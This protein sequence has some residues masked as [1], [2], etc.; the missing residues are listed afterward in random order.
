[1]IN[2]W[3]FLHMVGVSMS[4]RCLHSLCLTYVSPPCFFSH[5]PRLFQRFPFSD[6]MS[7]LGKSR[8]CL[9]WATETERWRQTI[10]QYTGAQGFPGLEVPLKGT[11]PNY[12][13]ISKVHPH[14]MGHT[15]LPQGLTYCRKLTK[16]WVSCMHISES[17]QL[18]WNEKNTWPFSLGFGEVFFL[19]DVCSL[20]C[21]H[22]SRG[23]R[24]VPE[25][26]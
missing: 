2:H 17:K 9:S 22:R 19:E 24:F 23:W 10:L 3:T 15:F 14:F 6:P 13:Q 21:R 12:S 11:A 20:H 8:L 5:I 16:S 18:I 1:M 26:T 25:K 7:W 4:H